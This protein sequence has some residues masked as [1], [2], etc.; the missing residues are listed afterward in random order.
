MDGCPVCKLASV[1]VVGVY[2]CVTDVCPYLAM[3]YIQ[4]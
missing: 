3:Y 4:W 1:G 2:V